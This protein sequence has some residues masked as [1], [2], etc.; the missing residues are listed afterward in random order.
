MSDKDPPNPFDEIQRQ[1]KELFKDSNITVSAQAFNDGNEIGEKAK[2]EEP[3]P[4]AKTEPE[5]TS[6]E[7]IRKFNLKPKEIRD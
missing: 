7:T 4:S 6:L 2:T 3:P 1:L 5:K